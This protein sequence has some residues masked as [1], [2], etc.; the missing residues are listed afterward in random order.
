MDTLD[1]LAKGYQES[2]SGN[3]L[4]PG[5]VASARTRPSRSVFYLSDGSRVEVDPDMPPIPPGLAH[6]DVWAGRAVPWI[7]WTTASGTIDLTE[8]DGDRFIGCIKERTCA[9]CA[10]PLGYGIGWI[11][12]DEP[13]SNAAGAERRPPKAR[14]A[15]LMRE[16]GMHRGCASYAS[17]VW[18]PDREW[19]LVARDYR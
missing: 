18:W 3:L 9:M 7:A 14:E 19:M 2:A 1:E 6:L 17:K 11:R 16:P 5:H 13:V 4:V 8:V 10:L 15:R 12:G